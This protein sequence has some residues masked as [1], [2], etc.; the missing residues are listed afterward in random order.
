MSTDMYI[1]I[2]MLEYLIHIQILIKAINSITH[3]SMA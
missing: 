3:V 2:Y 1:C